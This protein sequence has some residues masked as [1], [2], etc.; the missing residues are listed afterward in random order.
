MVGSA[1]MCH[2]GQQYFVRWNK[3]LARAPDTMQIRALAATCYGSLAWGAALSLA[4]AT[5]NVYAQG[6]TGRDALGDWRADRPGL[7]RHIS[8]ADLPKPWATPSDGSAPRIVGRPAEAKPLVPDGF[9]V[10]LFAEGLVTPRI[11]RAAPNGDMFVAETSANRIRLLRAGDGEQKP[12]INQIFADD[13]REPFGIAFYPQ[14]D[15]KWIYVANTDSVVRFAYHAGDIRAAGKPEVV[16]AN[17]PR[18]GRSTRDIAFSNDGKRMF[19]SVGSA[20][21]VG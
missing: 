18:G 2:L 19:I 11:I 16:V 8:T 1:L 9:E 10:S 14:N 4:A 15:P 3:A 17:L 7:T 20:T 12:S 13:L 21:N 6:L 5:T